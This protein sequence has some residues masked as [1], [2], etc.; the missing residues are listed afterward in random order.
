MG[1]A[2]NETAVDIFIMYSQ[3]FTAFYGWRVCHLPGF[4]FRRSAI[5]R[6][7][8][9]TWP[10]NWQL[11]KG[12]TIST[13]GK[14]SQRYPTGR[15]SQIPPSLQKWGPSLHGWLHLVFFPYLYV[16][17]SKYLYLLLYTGFLYTHTH[18][19]TLQSSHPFVLPEYS[20]EKIILMRYFQKDTWRRDLQ[21]FGRIP[22]PSFLFDLKV[23][24]HFWLLLRYCQIGLILPRLNAPVQSCLIKLGPNDCFLFF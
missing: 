20:R 14:S 15:D 21:L 23:M 6:Q 22:H 7:L 24:K 11:L 10:I 2:K 3:I 5:H 16:Y 19:Y 18:T 1:D 9:R 12:G 4:S 8:H 17:F 13:I